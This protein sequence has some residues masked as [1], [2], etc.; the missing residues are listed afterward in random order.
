M[1]LGISEHY[2]TEA[3]NNITAYEATANHLTVYDSAHQY[4]INF[5][6]GALDE[7]LLD[8]IWKMDSLQT[9][10]GK[11]MVGP[12]TL[13][14]IQFFRNRELQAITACQ[15]RRGFYVISEDGSLT[16]SFG[17]GGGWGNVCTD[18]LYFL[19]TSFFSGLATVSAYDGGGETL[20]LHNMSRSYVLNFSPE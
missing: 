1:C 8:V 5:S 18:R 17:Y 19:M 3:R 6:I 2:Y 10:D 20:T 4:E 9:P 13:L 12:D 7:K 16:V 11:I 15:G 14:S